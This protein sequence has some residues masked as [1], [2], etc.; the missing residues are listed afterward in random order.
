MSIIFALTVLAALYNVFVYKW[1]RSHIEHL[2]ITRHK[3]FMRTIKAD[4]GRLSEASLNDHFHE[5]GLTIEVDGEIRPYESLFSD[6]KTLSRLN[7]VE[8]LRLSNKY[9]KN[10]RFTIYGFAACLIVFAIWFQ[11]ST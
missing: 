8:V 6:K 11:S 4:S 7:D 10:K 5:V 1:T 9:I 3:G 2:L